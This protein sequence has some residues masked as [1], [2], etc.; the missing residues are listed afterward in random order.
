M[1]IRARYLAY[2]GLVVVVCWF[3]FLGREVLTPFVFAVVFAYLLDPVVSFFSD[4]IHLPRTLAIVIIYLGILA[5]LIGGGYFLGRR[6]VFEVKEFAH[7]TRIVFSETEIEKIISSLPDWAAAV[8]PEITTNLKNSVNF[9]AQQV[10][11]VF[12]GTLSSLASIFIFLMALFYFLQGRQNFYANIE[13]SLPLKFRVEF[14]IV[15]RKIQQ[16]LGGYFRAQ[17]LLVIIMSLFG[18]VLFNLLGI[19][20]ALILSLVIGLAEIIPIIGPIIALFCILLVGMISGGASSLSFPMALE[21]PLVGAIYLILN[22]LENM[23]IVPQITGRMVQLHPLLIL[24]SVLIGGQIFGAIGF[25]LAVPVVA[26]VK[27]I[28]NHLLDF[29]D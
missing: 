27:V 25:L 9:S 16:V 3:L 18:L 4:K 29:L 21:I 1:P 28:F 20:Y 6:L 24:I 17:M 14:V 8:L 15:I 26:S 10:A 19:R 23:F 11:K 2:I 12:S 22:Q 5:I 7:E 13:R